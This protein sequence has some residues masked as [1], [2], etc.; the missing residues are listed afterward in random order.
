MKID[1]L[2]LK[3][4]VTYEI[5]LSARKIGSV[6]EKIYQKEVTQILPNLT[7]EV[8]YR[9]IPPDTEVEVYRTLSRNGLLIVESTDYILTPSLVIA[10][11]NYDQ[12]E[13][14]STRKI[15]SSGA[16]S[17]FPVVAILFVL[18]SVVAIVLA[19]LLITQD[20]NVRKMK[21]Q[22][23]LQVGTVSQDGRYKWDG[24][25]WIQNSTDAEDEDESWVWNGSEWVP[26][27]KTYEK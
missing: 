7:I 17:S 1:L 19:A 3:S 8:P 14:N 13:E 10:E 15:E 24:M 9:D 16:N 22:F 21:S 23:Q 20:Y 6:P 12:P 25:K 4:G 2:C 18:I 26:N 27:V 5:K 11:E